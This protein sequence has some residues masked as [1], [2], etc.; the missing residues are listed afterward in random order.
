M[1]SAPYSERCNTLRKHVTKHSSG[2]NRPTILTSTSGPICY[3]ARH[4]F[5]VRS[6]TPPN[7]MPTLSSVVYGIQ[8]N[9]NSTSL[10]YIQPISL[11]S[12]FVY[13]YAIGLLRSSSGILCSSLVGAQPTTSSPSTPSPPPTLLSHEPEQRSDSPYKHQSPH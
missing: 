5:V 12:S 7:A 11:C 3:I 9:Y 2:L 4:V 8:Y 10:S 1:I 13:V 6:V